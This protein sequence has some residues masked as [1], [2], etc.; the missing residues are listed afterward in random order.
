MTYWQKRI[1]T[2]SDKLYNAQ[3][4]STNKDYANVYHN[5]LQGIQKDMDRLYDKLVKASPNGVVRNIDLYTYNRFYELQG[6]INKK[7]KQ[8]GQKEI[9]ILTDNMI[10]MYNITSAII[11]S[12]IPQKL[13]KQSFIT[14]PNNRVKQLLNYAWC[15]DGK[16]FSQRIWGNKALLQQKLEQGFTDCIT[17]GLSKDEMVK[18]LQND[19]GVGF[20]NADRIVRTELTYIQNQST[21]DSYQKAGITKYKFL[22]AID[23]RTSD[24]CEDLDGQVFDFAEMQVG[25][26]YPPLHPNCRSTIIAVF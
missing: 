5:A 16:N 22:A 13:I 19:F 24:I 3:L 20:S 26:N 18:Q 10:N 12:N 7:L 11:G 4:K 14:L 17:R 15:Q 2:A 8:L 25:I 6:Q 23:D 9:N 1:N 21:A